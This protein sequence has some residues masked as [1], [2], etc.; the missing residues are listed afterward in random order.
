MELKKT[1]LNE[2][3]KKLGGKL[4]DFAGW[5]LPIQFQGIKEE[6]LAVRE[7]AGLFDVSHMG[8]ITVEG[9]ESLKFVDYLVAND[10]GTLN[11][12]QVMYTFMCNEKG[13]VVDDLLVY[14]YS[15]EKILLVVN[16]SNIEKD[17]RWIEE[18]SHDFDVIT[19]NISEEVSQIAIQGP[20]AQEILQ[21]ITDIDLNEI[22]FFTFNSEV[23]LSG[24]ECLVSRTGY[25]G[26]DGFEIY[27]S[28]NA[29][30]SIVE[31]LL[32]VGGE[33]LSPIGLGARDT[34]RFEAGLPLYG[35]E[36]REDVTPLE[37]GLGF[38]VKLEAGD[39]IGKN[40]LVAQKKEG[41]KRKT[42][43]FKLIG[44]GIARGGY[45]VVAHGKEIGAVTTGYQL[46]GKK[47]SIG[48][49]LMDTEYAK[50]GTHIQI[51]I[52]KKL[53]DAQIISKKFLDKKYKK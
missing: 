29:A 32:N 36:L 13:G 35:N 1:S 22:K 28:N 50:L 9:L 18:K 15:N 27:L 2:V 10:A 12:N 47:E 34:L 46:P 43:G 26:E 38:F 45:K 44:K 14:K 40:I 17:Y 42:A 3:H 39:F 11:D 53:V 51:E 7:R 33:D 30:V 19:K 49:A 20:K 4:I 24:V 31:E 23:L 48:L 6:H 8:E 21:K 5:E 16:A 37:S 25:T 52:R 41:L